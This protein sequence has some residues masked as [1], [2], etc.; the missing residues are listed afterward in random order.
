MIVLHLSRLLGERKMNQA[1]LARLSGVRANTLNDMYHGTIERISFE[2][3]DRIC[4]VLD[5]E[6]AE[7]IER[8]PNPVP[9]TGNA[10]I[11]EEHGTRKKPP[12]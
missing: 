1:E 2:Q 12:R 10:L 3:L 5:C 9:R 4:E 11:L 6:L 8:R 7:L